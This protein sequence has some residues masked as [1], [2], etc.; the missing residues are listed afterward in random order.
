M[1]PVTIVHLQCNILN[2]ISSK[3]STAFILQLS[4]I[5]TWAQTGYKKV[6]LQFRCIYILA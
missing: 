5:K 2:L 1:V 4:H 3:I 6:S